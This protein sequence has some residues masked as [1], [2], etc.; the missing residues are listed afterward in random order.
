[1]IGHRQLLTSKNAHDLFFQAIELDKYDF[2]ELLLGQKIKLVESD[3]TTIRIMRLF[4]NSMSPLFPDT[5]WSKCHISDV[6]V[7]IIH[8]KRILLSSRLLSTYSSEND[9]VAKDQ[10]LPIQTLFIWALICQRLKLEWKICVF[11]QFLGTITWQ[12]RNFVNFL[13]ILSKT[14]F[15]EKF[16]F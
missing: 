15:F 1:M 13:R 2:V 4:K 9:P 6:A 3:D 11:C 5:N 10:F 12:E 14:I 8:A 16:R 7:D